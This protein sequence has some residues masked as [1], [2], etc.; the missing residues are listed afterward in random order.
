MENSNLGIKPLAAQTMADRVEE[1]LGNYF[2]EKGFKPGDV[3][4]RELELAAALGVSRNVVREA[5]SRF[6]MLGIIESKKK[7]GMVLAMPDVTVAFEKVTDPYLLDKS[8][9]NDL[10]E[11]RLILELGMT[12]ILF[13]RKNDR[14]LKELE[15]IIARENNAESEVERILCDVEFHRVLYKMSGNETL[16]RFQ[17]LLLPV[18]EHVMEYEAKHGKVDRGDISH[19]D[20]LDIL[21]NGTSVEFREAMTRHLE[22]HLKHVENGSKA[23]FDF[24]SD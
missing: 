7:R 6:K 2:R 10:F 15:E 14:Y 1:S 12:D 4:P 21:K 20:L 11:L 17:K 24:K 5:L 22:P 9:K 13:L 8:S 3:L 19:Q 18:F 16:L 23:G